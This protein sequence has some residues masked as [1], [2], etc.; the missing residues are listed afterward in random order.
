MNTPNKNHS[1]PIEEKSNQGYIVTIGRE[2][3]RVVNVFVVFIIAHPLPYIRL[4]VHCELC[5]FYIL[6]RPVF[7]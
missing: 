1:L 3:I 6:L 7:S 4:R 5:P 2:R